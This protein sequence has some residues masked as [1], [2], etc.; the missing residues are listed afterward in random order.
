[1]EAR[2]SDMFL[3][4]LMMMMMM[5]KDVS[6]TR[7]SCDAALVIVQCVPEATLY[8]FP[9]AVEPSPRDPAETAILILILYLY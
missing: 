8:T 4:K 3:N 2:A 6:L 5:Q 1:M 9:G 7:Q